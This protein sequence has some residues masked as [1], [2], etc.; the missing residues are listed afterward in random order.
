M[1][2]RG[3]R[4]YLLP[5]AGVSAALE[6]GCF[7]DGIVRAVRGMPLQGT[8][9]QPRLA[10]LAGRCSLAPMTFTIKESLE[11]PR[12]LTAQVTPSGSGCRDPC[13]K[14]PRAHYRTRRK[15]ASCQFLVKPLPSLGCIAAMCQMFRELSPMQTREFLLI[16]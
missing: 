2:G 1:L 6:D 11:V 4:G 8:D 14:C 12:A 5:I 3:K 9:R 13:W 15:H 16:H 10:S 7:A